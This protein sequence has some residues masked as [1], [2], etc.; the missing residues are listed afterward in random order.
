MKPKQIA[1][2]AS[3]N[4]ILITAVSLL[5]QIA[6]FVLFI[7][8]LANYSAYISFTLTLLSILIMLYIVNKN[9]NPSYKICWLLLISAFP[10]L[11][12]LLYLFFGDKKP[13]R[14]MAAKLRRSQETY[15]TPLMQNDTVLEEL[16]A[17][18][19]RFAGT[20]K[21]IYDICGYP[22]YK[23]TEVT[24]FSMGENMYEA[25]LSELKKAK[26][27]IF[28]EYFIINPGKMWDSILEI[29]V[30]KAHSGVDVRIIYDDMACVALLPPG[31]SNFLEALDPN[32]KCIAFNP[33]VPLFSVVMNNRDH[34]KILVI[35]GCTA[36]TGG[37]N[38][39]DEYVNFISPYGVWKDTGVM[40]KGDAAYSFTEMFLEMWNAFRNDND[41]ITDFCP[42]ST[43]TG[44]YSSD[45]YVIPFSDTPLDNESLGE[46]VY[47]EIINR[48]Q[49]YVYIFTPYLI[50][51]DDMKTAL[52]LAAKRGVDVRIVTPGIPDKKIVYRMTRANY[53]PL[54]CAGVRIF[55]Y[56]PGFIHAKSY[57]SDDKI[58]IV[59]TIN[60]DYRSLYLH[61]ECGTLMY[62][63]SC[64]EQLKNDH[65]AIMEQSREIT[66]D[67]FKN[68]YKGTMFDAF[69]RLLAPLL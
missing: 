64:L 3:L 18:D 42:N 59:G 33:V 1:K 55:E 58:G 50:I 37:I 13:A 51:D 28:L 56:T 44:E 16:Y 6:W 49:S 41:D 14:K 12:G 66:L 23:N 48:A 45:G 65:Q 34:R 47:L 43:V 27:F 69:L 53:S 68:Y 35:D 21:Y 25:M 22:S 9:I 19:R 5:V 61:F 31:Y 4:R 32:I 7:F 46:S 63:T 15:L 60:M 30:D 36:F 52:S 17:E 54:L 26:R 57:I 67:N 8:R 2:I 40:V 10:I 20:C 24:Y 29:L 11:G 39:S 62:N 38:L